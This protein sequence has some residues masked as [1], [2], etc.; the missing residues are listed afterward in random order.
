MPIARTVE[1]YLE[2]NRVPYEIISHRHTLTSSDTAKAAAVSP[3]QIA[4]SVILGDARG[5]LMAVVP[6]DDHVDVDQ[7]SGRLGRQLRL[8]PENTLAQLFSDCERGAIPPLGR[9][10]G[11]DTIVDDR[12][13]V[14]DHVCFTAGDHDALVRV[15][16]ESFRLLIKGAGHA[17]IGRA[18]PLNPTHTDAAT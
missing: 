13:L 11:I 14:Q 8:V 7:L 6:G 1:V 15:D 10:Y 3:R 2:Q 12:V 17:P 18:T 4:K 9:A 16:N 5:H